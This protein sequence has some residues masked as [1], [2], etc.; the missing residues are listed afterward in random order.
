MARPSLGV[1]DYNAL[2][3]EKNLTFT[4]IIVPVSV[5]EKTTWTCEVCH[6][7]LHKSY[8]TLK[9]AP[10]P[11][12]CRNGMSLKVEDYYNLALKLGIQYASMFPPANVFEKAQWVTSDLRSFSASYHE[13]GY[14]K[15]PSHLKEYVRC[16]S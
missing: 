15:I 1:T 11:C 12:R 13:L 14:N 9:Y 16:G 8:H 6:K 2:A 4:G 7:V 5:N 3:E 10:N